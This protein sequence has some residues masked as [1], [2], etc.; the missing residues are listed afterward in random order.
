MK[1]TFGF[2]A[3]IWAIFLALFNAIVFIIPHFTAFGGAFWV[4][5]IFITLAFIGQLICAFF[6]F[7]ADNKQ[8]LFY[9]IPLIT[10]SYGGLIAMLSAGAICMKIPFL[11]EWLGIILCLTVLAFNAVAVIKAVYLSSTVSEIDNKVKEKT[12]FMKNLT[13]DAL[14]LY[15]TCESDALKPMAKKVYE[16]VRYSDPMSSEAL[17]NEENDVQLSFSEFKDAILREDMVS[18]EKAANK[19]LS[20]INLRNEKCKLLK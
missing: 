17:F 6:A 15:S 13:L 8:K 3:I 11:P 14:H 10:L 12:Y 4:G 2:Y 16:A 1:K 7:K 18:A 5:Y 9:N 19:V 20:D